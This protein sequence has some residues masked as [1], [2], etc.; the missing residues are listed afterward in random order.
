[1]FSVEDK[2]PGYLRR[3]ALLFVAAAV[4]VGCVSTPYVSKKRHGNLE[5]TVEIV[6]LKWH[7]N[8]YPEIIVDGNPLGHVSE[9]RPVLYLTEGEHEIE[10]RSHGF[11]VCKTTIYIAG[12]PNH[13]YLRMI[14]EKIP[15]VPL[16]TAKARR[17]PVAETP[18]EPVQ[19]PP[20]GTALEPQPP[21]D[22]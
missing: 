19:Q 18:A 14:L 11:Y 22:S 10:V 21:G 20:G 4:L 2:M 5:V 3:A 17:Q 7:E 1:M 8:I 9:H 12:A 13:Q 15:E 16:G 6:G